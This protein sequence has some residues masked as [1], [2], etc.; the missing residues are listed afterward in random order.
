MGFLQKKSWLRGLW[1]LKAKRERKLEI[2]RKNRRLCVVKQLVKAD[3]QIGTSVHLS[4]TFHLE[5][6]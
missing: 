4:V 1:I 6:H 5:C 3:L 2:E